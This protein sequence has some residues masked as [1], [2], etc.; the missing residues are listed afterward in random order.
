MIWATPE[1]SELVKGIK[2]KKILKF[3]IA[4]TTNLGQELGKSIDFYS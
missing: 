3:Y 2:M 4:K 1:G